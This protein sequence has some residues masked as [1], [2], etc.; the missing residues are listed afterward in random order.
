MQK[1][2]AINVRLD[3]K[4]ASR[5]SS[6]NTNI[7]SFSFKI[8]EIDSPLTSKLASK[9]QDRKLWTNYHSSQIIQE[10]FGNLPFSHRQF[11]VFQTLHCKDCPYSRILK[12]RFQLHLGLVLILLKTY[13]ALTS[14]GLQLY[15]KK[16][17]TS[18]TTSGIDT[19]LKLITE[20]SWS[21]REI[22]LKL[23]IK[24]SKKK[25]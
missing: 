1:H 15:F 23:T 24:T 4:Y 21:I 5:E 9:Y 6:Y 2:F 11:C 20:N 3:S 8:K 12:W 25:S 17:T 19:C 13:Y 22:R 18:T 7:E 14:P 16:L 10:I